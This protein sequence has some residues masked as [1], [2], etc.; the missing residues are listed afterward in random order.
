MTWWFFNGG[1][2]LRY[3]V[4]VE[5]KELFVALPLKRCFIAAVLQAEKSHLL[6][7]FLPPYFVQNRLLL[8]LLSEEERH[9][10][11]CL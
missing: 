11:P 9:E 1:A 8:L 3:Q 10:M 2:G 7:V 5:P 4:E 6:T